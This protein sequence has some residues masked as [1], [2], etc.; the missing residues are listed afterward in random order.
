MKRQ[1]LTAAVL[2][3]SMMLAAPALARDPTRGLDAGPCGDTKKEKKLKVKVV[4]LP[5]GRKKIIIETALELCGTIQKPS[6]F[7][8]LERRRLHT[9]V[10]PLDRVFTDRI[11]ESVRKSPF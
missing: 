4:T 1:L 3:A 8:L 11:L 2:V 7:Y 5:N 10:T 9:S 6:A